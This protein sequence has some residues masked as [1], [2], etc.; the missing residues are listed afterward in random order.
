V[1]PSGIP[2]YNP[3]GDPNG[4]SVNFRHARQG[5][6]VVLAQSDRTVNSLALNCSSCNAPVR[7]GA[8]RCDYCGVQVP[9]WVPNARP[10]SAPT[11]VGFPHAPQ[12]SVYRPSP[13]GPVDVRKFFPAVAAVFARYVDFRGRASLAE[14]WWFEAFQVTVTLSI[15][16]G[17]P[18]SLVAFWTVLT[19]VPGIAVAVRR[20]HD[21]RKS[22]W[23]YLWVFTGVGAFVVLYWMTLPSDS[24]PDNPWG[25]PR[26]L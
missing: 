26:P 7:T 4:S 19:F 12:A 2:A 24:S 25:P 3:A 23:N 6:R 9:G 16:H 20:L 5:G 21:V 22:G 8:A 1:V 11:L 15:R 18:E 10:P 17:V 14:F 13:R